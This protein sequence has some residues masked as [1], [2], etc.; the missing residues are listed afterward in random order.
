MT[1]REEA[2][3]RLVKRG[4]R[5]VSGPEPC[6]ACKVA[7]E[8]WYSSK[9][10]WRPYTSE[11]LDPHWQMCKWAFQNHKPPTGPPS[12]HFHFRYGMR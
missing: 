7:F 9:I 10:G 11:T 2:E 3:Q 12:T 5:R 4:L 8:W 6:A 1:N